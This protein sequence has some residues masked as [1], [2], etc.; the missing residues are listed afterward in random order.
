MCNRLCFKIVL[1]WARKQGRKQARIVQ[2]ELNQRS[3]EQV[4]KS[5]RP[6]A[7]DFKYSM[8]FNN[9]SSYAISKAQVLRVR[10]LTLLQWYPYP[11]P[12]K[13]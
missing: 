1:S 9:S 6:K 13:I 8:V 3:T 5:Y 2:L 4:Q 7:N 10:L 12:N 11:T